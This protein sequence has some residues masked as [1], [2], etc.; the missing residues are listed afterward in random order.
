MR[1]SLLFAAAIACITSSVRA[2]DTATLD[3][4]KMNGTWEVIEF[5]SGGQARS[6]PTE[7]TIENGVLSLFGVMF[8]LSLNTDT[9]PRQ[10]DL[11]T[12]NRTQYNRGIY[13]F[14][15]GT[16]RISFGPRDVA[17]DNPEARPATFNTDNSYYAHLKLRRK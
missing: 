8:N 15:G 11:K 14:S 17:D 5:I 1:V 10:I 3:L 2:E 13:D 9:N 4:A 6:E 12:P 16:F 7:L